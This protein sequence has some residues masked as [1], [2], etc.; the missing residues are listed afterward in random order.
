[1]DLWGCMGGKGMK[2][3]LVVRGTAYHPLTLLS[4]KFKISK[5]KLGIETTTYAYHR[6]G[7]NIICI[8]LFKNHFENVCAN[9]LFRVVIKVHKC[10]C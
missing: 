10:T 1:M 7:V 8:V 4:R 6:Y 9:E 3:G 5:D 2:Y